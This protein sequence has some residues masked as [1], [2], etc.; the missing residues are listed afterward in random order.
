MRSQMDPQ[1]SSPAGEEAGLYNRVKAYRAARSWSQ[2]ELAQRT[3]LSRAGISAMEIGRLVPSTAAALTLARVFGC[4]VEDL[5]ELAAARDRSPGWAW[6]PPRDACRYWL[7]EVRGRR[8]LYPVET[9]QL[10]LTPHDG[11][12]QAGR[13]RTSQTRDPSQTLV[14]A[15]CDPAAG[16]LAA[17]MAETSPFRLLVL[18]R[19]TR[20]ALAL[21]GRGLVHAA[22]LH[23]GQASDPAGNASVVRETVGGGYRLLRIARWEEGVA[24]R[25]EL[26][27]SSFRAATRSGIRW[28]WRENGS[29]ARRWL[30]ELLAGRKGARRIATDHRGVADAIR[31]GWADAGVCH[32]LLSEEAQLEFLGF[33]QEAYDLCYPADLAG[34]PRLQT[35]ME[36]VRSADFRRQLEELPGFAVTDTGE[37]Q[38]VD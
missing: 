36:I 35:L 27:L 11:V 12:R 20:D 3:G 25:A 16:L 32:R 31:C 37:L 33:P 34:D 29:A 21:L 15:T 8:W 17:R 19:C 4:T 13:L 7:A 22:G 2:E 24:Y 1:S 30:D 9:S 10:G 18:Q 23:L 38:P 5:F 6:E 26:H 28:V 14:I